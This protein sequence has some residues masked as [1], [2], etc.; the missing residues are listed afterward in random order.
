M[1]SEIV[2]LLFL[3]FQILAFFFSH[4]PHPPGFYGG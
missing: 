4:A 1:A 3:L 2:F